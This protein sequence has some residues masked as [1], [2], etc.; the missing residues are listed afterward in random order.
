VSEIK[1]KHIDGVI[2]RELVSGEY[3]RRPEQPALPAN[4][5]SETNVS[6]HHC[7][8]AYDFRHPLGYLT[9]SEAASPNRRDNA[10]VRYHCRMSIW[11]LRMIRSCVR[12]PVLSVHK[13]SITPKFWIALR[14]FTITRFFDI[15]IAPL[16]RFAV[17]IIGSI[18]GV[19]PTR[20]GDRE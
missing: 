16:A 5:Y 8:S 1:S 9:A 15:A 7:N 11:R 3:A 17:T 2:R 14:R 18:S 20:D 12:V 10:H 19:K 4:P 13:T 6:A